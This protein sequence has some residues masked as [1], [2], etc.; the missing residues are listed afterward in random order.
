MFTRP[1]AAAQPYNIN[2]L[3]S[4]KQ[5]IETVT[6][7]TPNMRALHM[8]YMELASPRPVVSFSLFDSQTLMREPVTDYVFMQ[9]YTGNIVSSSI[10]S[11]GE[12]T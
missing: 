8:T 4:V 2:D 12:G 7:T 9:P 10:V 5:L 11:S 6:A 3:P 1:A